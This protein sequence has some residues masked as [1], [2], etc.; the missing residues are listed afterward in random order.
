LGRQWSPVPRPAGSSRSRSCRTAHSP[1]IAARRSGG[2]R[3]A[4]AEVR[5]MW[6]PA[7]AARR[8]ATAGAAATC[9][10]AKQARPGRPAS[11]SRGRTSGTTDSH[12]L[13]ASSSADKCWSTEFPLPVTTRP[14][15]DPRIG[16][17]LRLKELSGST[18]PLT[19][20]YGGSR[21]P[22]TWTTANEWRRSC[23]PELS[24]INRGRCHQR[25]DASISRNFGGT[26]EN[27]AV[28]HDRGSS[29]RIG[30][31][32]GAKDQ[33]SQPP[34]APSDRLRRCPSA[35]RGLS[36]EL[37]VPEPAKEIVLFR[38]DRKAARPPAQRS[39][40]SLARTNPR[41]PVPA[42]WAP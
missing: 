13:E 10:R 1:G 8:M 15:G 28:G 14:A 4:A 9:R 22:S 6:S 17:R 21:S 37:A 12:S 23:N 16:R 38:C 2:R 27:R 31:R 24:E 29:I 30:G 5:R 35:V 41:V 42:V 19:H 32:L 25:G 26:E 33:P 36:R 40:R 34:A 7:P 39:T 18:D 3:T 20:D 11:E